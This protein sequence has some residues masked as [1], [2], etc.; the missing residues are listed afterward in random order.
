MIIKQIG[1][2]CR[3]GVKWFWIWRK[4][5]ELLL[6]MGLNGF[7]WN[8]NRILFRSFQTID[9]LKQHDTSNDIAENN[10]LHIHRLRLNLQFQW[11]AFFLHIIEKKW[12]FGIL[13]NSMQ[14]SLNSISFMFGHKLK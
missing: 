2:T 5:V 7:R 3:L 13:V 10:K 11:K 8:V 4:K 1:G 9:F 14:L 6:I 12:I